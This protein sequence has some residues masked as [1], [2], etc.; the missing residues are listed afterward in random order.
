MA[1]LETITP[2]RTVNFQNRLCIGNPFP[3]SKTSLE[4]LQKSNFLE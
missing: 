4:E 2:V 3:S 1:Q